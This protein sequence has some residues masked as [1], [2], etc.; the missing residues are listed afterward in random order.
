MGKVTQHLRPLNAFFL[1]VCGFNFMQ[2]TIACKTLNERK[3]GYNVQLIISVES[4]M[5][6]GLTKNTSVNSA[7]S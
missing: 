3:F 1:K 4:Q 2:L 5:L 6:S 7:V